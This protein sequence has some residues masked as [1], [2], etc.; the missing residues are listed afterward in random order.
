MKNFFIQKIKALRQ[1][2]IKSNKVNNTSNYIEV[3]QKFIGKLRNEH[4]GKVITI[5]DIMLDDYDHTAMFLHYNG[6]EKISL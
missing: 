5:T 6:Y 2:F 4:N 3:G 1:L